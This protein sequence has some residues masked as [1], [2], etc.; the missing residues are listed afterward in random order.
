[1]SMFS[2]AVL[3]SVTFTFYEV[4][5]VSVHVVIAGM[6]TTPGILKVWEDLQSNQRDDCCK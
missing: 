2:N 5:V 4:S 1:M 3:L 6:I